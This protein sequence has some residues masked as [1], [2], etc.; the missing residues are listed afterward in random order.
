MSDVSL[1]TPL[2]RIRSELDDPNAQRYDDTYIMGFCDQCNEDLIIE[3][4]AKGIEYGEQR[5]EII[6]LPINTTDLSS[7]QASGGVLQYMILPIAMEWKNTGEPAT[8]YQPVFRVDK[9]ADVQAID[10]IV[11]W[12]FR[13]SV[14][15]LTPSDAILDL[16]IRFFGM[17]AT[18]LSTQQS[19]VTRA[20]VNVFVYKVA[21]KIASRNGNATLA[22]DLEKDRERALEN[23][24]ELMIKQDQGVR[25]RFGRQ[26]QPGT[27][28]NWRIPTTST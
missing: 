1:S 28:T 10:G 17:P 6:G 4:A 22:A 25:R 19:T 27:G 11:N 23:I 20:M 5:L 24:E 18:S 15:F 16:R 14:I 26:N 8:N 7:Y 21:Q 2:D 9:L 13:S 3:L 12:E